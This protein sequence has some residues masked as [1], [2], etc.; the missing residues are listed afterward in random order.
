MPLS[1]GTRCC[2]LP[3]TLTMRTSQNSPS[4]HSGEYGF[5]SGSLL[6]MARR[7]SA[8]AKRSRPAGVSCPGRLAPSVFDALAVLESNEVHAVLSHRASGRGHPHQGPLMGARGRRASRSFSCRLVR[9]GSVARIAG[10]A[11]ALWD[12]AAG[13]AVPRRLWRDYSVNPA[14]PPPRRTARR[15]NSF[16]LT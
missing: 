9:P 1:G 16:P 6:R 7:R 14:G 2:Q 10:P 11:R 4:T 12:R 13:A 5:R 8:R 3:R 15:L